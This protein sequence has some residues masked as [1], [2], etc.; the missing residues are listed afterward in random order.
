MLEE[1]L[2]RLTTE[3]PDDAVD[4]GVLENVLRRGHRIRSVQVFSRVCISLVL[5]GL[6]GSAALGFHR[7]FSDAAIHANRSPGRPLATCH[8]FTRSLLLQDVILSADASVIAFRGDENEGQSFLVACGQGRPTI[9]RVYL[10]SLCL[11]QSGNITWSG[12]SSKY[13]CLP[14]RTATFFAMRPDGRHV[15]FSSYGAV[16]P[17][18]SNPGSNIYDLDTATGRVVPIRD[19]DHA[20]GVDDTSPVITPDGSSLTFVRRD[21]LP[22]VRDPNSGRMLGASPDSRYFVVRLDLRTG[23]ETARPLDI[24][25]YQTPPPLSFS[26]ASSFTKRTTIGPYHDLAVFGGLSSDGNAVALAGSV[27]SNLPH[28]W[29]NDLLLLDLRTGTFH[30]VSWDPPW[31]IRYEQAIA[32]ALTDLLTAVSLLVLY[33]MWMRRRTSVRS[34]LLTLGLIGA[35]TWTWITL[36]QGW[37]WWPLLAFGI[38]T[39]AALVD[40]V[41]VPHG[42]RSKRSVFASGL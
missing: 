19:P 13:D 30:V 16:V 1:R 7:S 37:P 15:Y 29:T 22:P 41:R 27:H 11:D 42:R 10:G 4:K 36:F 17:G 31:W 33:A 5:V 9:L 26:S 34:R 14:S 35:G 21:V 24:D 6:S 32:M 20:P 12:S 39:G 28:R 23:S 38:A 8:G 18:T 40:I 3:S 2:R 25:S